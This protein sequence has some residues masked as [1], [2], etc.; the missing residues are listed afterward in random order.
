M[1]FISGLAAVPLEYGLQDVLGRQGVQF[2]PWVG[3]AAACFATK[4]PIP[5][6]CST[7]S[8]EGY[9]RL[10]QHR[11]SVCFA[12]QKGEP[13]RS[14]L[15]IKGTEP[16]APDFGCAL[17]RLAVSRAVDNGLNH[18]ED[19]VLRE[20]KL[21]GC[22]LLRE[23]QAEASIAAAVH[24]RLSDDGGPLARLPLPILCVR[25][26]EAAAESAA[27]EI[28]S[29]ASRSLWHKIHMLAA[30]GLGAYV[31]WYPNIPLRAYQAPPG[32]RLAITM[33]EGWINLA[34]RLLRAGFLPTTAYS[35]D[36]GHCCDRRNAVIDG[37]FVDMGS[38]VPVTELSASPDVF[39]AL[40]MTIWILA[41]TILGVLGKNKY[42]VGGFDYVANMVLHLVRE[43]LM[44]ACGKG[45]DHRMT[46]FFEATKNV[47]AVV[48]LLEQT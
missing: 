41:G 46:E 18:L 4:L 1:E 48:R 13:V 29:R 32:R 16:L 7:F 5:P 14:V 34:A 10:Q 26:P 44:C 11:R 24:R 43:R 2:E 31:Y 28:S 9:F 3:S 37:G 22:L 38:V 35:Q 19:L 39:I 21:P 30:T 45:V 20:D 15:C 40:Q 36:R 17:D 12:P 23:A 6:S 47:S 8:S 27:R 33:A 25:L 42:R